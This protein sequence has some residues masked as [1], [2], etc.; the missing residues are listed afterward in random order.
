[1]SDS[2]DK[3]S[4]YLEMSDADFAALPNEEDA[5]PVTTEPEAEVAVPPETE[6]VTAD[7]AVT[8]PADNTTKD[9]VPDTVEFAEDFD[10]KAAYLKIRQPFKAGGQTVVI[11]NDDEIISL[12]QKGIGFTAK[13]QK[14]AEQAKLAAVL[15]KGQISM[16]DL[17]FLI[18]LKHQKPDAIRKLIKDAGVDP[19]DIDTDSPDT[20]Q[21]GNYTVTEKELAFT[22]ALD[23]LTSTPEG[24][25][26]VSTIHTDWDSS[27]KEVLWDNVGIMTIMAE[28]Y[29]SG[30]Y[31]MVTDEMNRQKLVG[32]L[33]TDLP[34]IQAYKAV[35]DQLLES[36]KA[37]TAEPEV[38][39]VDVGNTS[40]NVV[41]KRVIAPKPNFANDAKARAANVAAQPKHN[42]SSSG[43][44][45]LAMSDEDFLKMSL[46]S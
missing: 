34:F 18:D 29:Q 10:Y 25:E 16:E 38:A 5:V 13:S 44:N 1:M 45:P 33:P 22:N 41:A 17:P 2:E 15:E 37:K 21:A 30:V 26:F 28:Q 7:T 46:P 24:K 39:T 11:K 14:L 42:Q 23:E 43:K 6:S 9:T 4:N 32:K 20:Y 35:G 40:A 8:E 3:Q 31:K 12:M 27:S 36:S 19:L